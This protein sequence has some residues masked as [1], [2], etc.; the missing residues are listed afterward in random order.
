MRKVS[1]KDPNEILDSSSPNRLKYQL[2][3]IGEV[4]DV[5][6]SQ[7]MLLKRFSEHIPRI[8]L[9]K[10]FQTPLGYSILASLMAYFNELLKFFRLVKNTQTFGDG[11]LVELFHSP[12]DIPEYTFYMVRCLQMLRDV[13]ANKDF[14]AASK[15][16]MST[17]FEN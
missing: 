17:I 9:S 6:H 8:F 1:F 14:M 4:K 7:E 2:R 12:R 16:R 10:Q 13:S 15:L 5:K 11:F 3:I